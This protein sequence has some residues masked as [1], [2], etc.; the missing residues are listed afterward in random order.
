MAPSGGEQKTIDIKNKGVSDIKRGLQV[1]MF[2]GSTHRSEEKN[3]EVRK[4]VLL[5]QMLHTKPTST[6]FR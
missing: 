2:E 5:K 4:Y 1:R 6:T 3:E